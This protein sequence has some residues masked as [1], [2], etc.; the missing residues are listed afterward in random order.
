MCLLTSR[1]SQVTDSIDTVVQQKGLAHVR[2]IAFL[3][4]QLFVCCDLCL[5]LD[6]P[7]A[8]PSIPSLDEETSSPLSA[9]P[10]TSR[11]P[12]TAIAYRLTYRLRPNAGGRTYAGFEFMWAAPQGGYEVVRERL[13]GTSGVARIAEDCFASSH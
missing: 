8:G 4:H 6:R 5:F 9:I 11:L 1:Q 13:P 2:S 7:L 12:P 10:P 3:R